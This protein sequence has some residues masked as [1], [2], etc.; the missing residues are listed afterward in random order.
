MD[1]RAYFLTFGTYGSRLHGDERETWVRRDGWAEVP[2]PFNPRRARFEAAELKQEPVTITPAM[3][4]VIEAAIADVCQHREWTLLAL[5]VRLE[6]VH[7]V[8]VAEGV[9][10]ERVVNDVKAYATRRMREQGLVGPVAKFGRGTPARTTCSP[11]RMLRWRW[12]TR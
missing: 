12:I 7:A 8:V 1:V 11:M 4:S 5:N 9:A 3:R 6:H 2:Q 10:P